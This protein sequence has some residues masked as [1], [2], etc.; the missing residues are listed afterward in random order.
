MIYR[1]LKGYKYELRFEFVYQTGI[2]H[3]SIRTPYISL[4]TRGNLIIHKHYMWD[5]PSGPTIDTKSFMHGS[6]VHDALYQLMREGRLDRKFREHADW[7]LKKICLA[8]G[9]LKFR[10]WYVYKAIRM[11]GEKSSYK[12]KKPRGEIVTLPYPVLKGKTNG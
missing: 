7:L 8:D 9:M 5:G 1:K 2:K 12:S 11:F 6:L 10:A 3:H 4:T